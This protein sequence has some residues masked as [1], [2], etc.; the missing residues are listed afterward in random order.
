MVLETEAGI[1]TLADYDTADIVLRPSAKPHLA[2]IIRC[3]QIPAPKDLFLAQL[4]DFCAACI[5]AG[6][7]RVTGEQGLQSLRLIA[8]LYSNRSPLVDRWYGESSEGLWASA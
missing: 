2:E 8:E 3:D 4:E 7:P 6:S 5:Q 1:V